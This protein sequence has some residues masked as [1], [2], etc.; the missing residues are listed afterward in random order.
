MK[1]IFILLNIILLFSLNIYSKPV[2]RISISKSFRQRT[3]IAFPPVYCD[4]KVSKDLAAEIDDIIR[5]DIDLSGLKKKKCVKPAARK[6]LI[7]RIMQYG[8]V[9]ALNV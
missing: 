5:T 7:K 8:K 2:L 9:W 3:I 1:K 4:D 6:N